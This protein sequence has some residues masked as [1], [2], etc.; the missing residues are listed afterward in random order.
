MFGTTAPASPSV[1][2][3]PPHERMSVS[4]SP[5]A[6]PAVSPTPASS[7]SCTVTAN[8]PVVQAVVTAAEAGPNALNFYVIEYYAA[9]IAGKAVLR[10]PGPVTAGQA[11]SVTGVLN[12]LMT[13]CQVTGVVVTS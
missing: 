3:T 12:S 7:A 13:S 5:P 6:T 4:P 10:V 11:V 2:G 1:T 9:G 8:E